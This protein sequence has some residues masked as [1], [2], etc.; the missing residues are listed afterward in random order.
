MVG[1]TVIGRTGFSYKEAQQIIDTGEG[2]MRSEMLTLNKLARILREKRFRSGAV[3]FE[4]EEVKIEVDEQGR[5][6]RIYA[7]EHG[8]SNELIEEFMLLANK[9]VAERIGKTKDKAEKKTFVYRIHDNPDTEKLQKFSRFIKKF[10]YQL[11]LKS[12]RQ[13]AL[14]LNKLLN[15]VKGTREQDIVENLAYAQWPKRNIQPTI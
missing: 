14:S 9:R 12:G 5:P 8:L 15:D 7:R 6:V 13:I 10:G 11:S 1:R 4:R 2:D 3:A